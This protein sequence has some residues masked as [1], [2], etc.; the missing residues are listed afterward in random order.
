MSLPGPQAVHP[1]NGLKDTLARLTGLS[2][3]ELNESLAL[4]RD[5]GLTSLHRL[6]LALTL[7][8]IYPVRIQDSL[9]D[10][11][12]IL[13]E[14]ENLIA[15]GEIRFSAASFRRSFAYTGELVERH[16]CPLIFPEGERTTTGR[17]LPFKEGI[18]HL[19]IS[20]GVP[21]VP[22]RIRGTR[23]ILPPGSL[24]PKRGQA[25]VHI[26]RSCRGSEKAAQRRR[27]TAGRQGSRTCRP[28]I[29]T[30]QTW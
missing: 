30:L 27:P 1:P 15:G 16:F 12:T 10:E 22:I 11:R 7:E 2:A 6:E 4:G 28:L 3:A 23:D 21:V 26:G 19:A 20:L 18:G 17:L 29:P 24:I 14:I 5:P 25:S 8:A 13:K 9:L